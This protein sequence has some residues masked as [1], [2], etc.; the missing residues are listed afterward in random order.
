VPRIKQL[1]LV[2]LFCILCVMLVSRGR[3]QQA[4]LDD[5]IG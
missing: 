1:A 4:H 2:A 5:A 3:A